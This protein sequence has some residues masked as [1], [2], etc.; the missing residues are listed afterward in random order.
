MITYQNRSGKV[1]AILRRK[2][3]GSKSKTF[4]TKG[5]AK[6]WAERIERE[7]A[8]REARSED[9][10]EDLTL[11]E[12][13]NWHDLESRRARSTMIGGGSFLCERPHLKSLLL[14][15]SCSSSG[16]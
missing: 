16:E 14:A 15:S 12:L 9:Y 1:R 2:G 8:E 10:L 13:I 11:A 3:I 7:F 4:P 6:I 5:L